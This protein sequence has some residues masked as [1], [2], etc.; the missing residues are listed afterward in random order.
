MMCHRDSDWAHGLL[1]RHAQH[2]RELE[3]ST[4]DREALQAVE[5]MPLLHVL[6]ISGWDPGL[7]KD[8][9]VY[10]ADD[11]RSGTKLYCL[12]I[13]LPLTTSV[14]LFLFFFFWSEVIKIRKE[15]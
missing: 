7:Q 6:H 3:V 10:A 13:S 11:I 12:L 15:V 1:A 14:I 5:N 8:P 9:Y 4:A 2:L